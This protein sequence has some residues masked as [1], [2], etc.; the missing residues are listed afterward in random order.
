MTHR[1][2]GWTVNE[3]ERLIPTP[4]EWQEPVRWN[5]ALVGEEAV[6]P[7]VI[8]DTDWLDARIDLQDWIEF[9]RLIQRTPR[10]DWILTSLQ[11]GRF[12]YRIREAKNLLMARMHAATDSGSRLIQSDEKYRFFVREVMAEPLEK[13]LAKVQR[14]ASILEMI[15][16]WVCSDVEE[17]DDEPPKNVWMATTF[18]TQAEADERMSP[19]M[20]QPAYVHALLIEPLKEAINLENGYMANAGTVTAEFVNRL[21]QYHEW[22]RGYR[23][24]AGLW[25]YCVGTDA[26]LHPEWVRKLRDECAY[27]KVPFYFAGWGEYAPWD[28]RHF[29]PAKLPSAIKLRTRMMPDGK[30]MEAGTRLTRDGMDAYQRNGFYMVKVGADKSG[31]LLDEHEWQEAP[32]L[33]LQIGKQA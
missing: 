23:Q 31:S 11:P 5:D 22:E 14:D 17:R 13:L 25:V 3:F 29:K 4:E 30:F 21:E 26:P 19:L 12:A 15:S 27:A 1:F 8:C 10:L 20:D 6:R 33:P 9:L 24:R 32:C 16:A 28:I 7:R 2:K 18:S